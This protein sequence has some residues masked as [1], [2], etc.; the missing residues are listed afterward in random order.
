MTMQQTIDELELEIKSKIMCIEGI[1][2]DIE[3]ATHTVQ[4]EQ[5]RLKNLKQSLLKNKKELDFFNWV[6]KNK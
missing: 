4:A 1:E 2:K 6:I 5:S 3:E